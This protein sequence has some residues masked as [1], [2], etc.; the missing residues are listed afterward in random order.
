MKKAAIIHG[1]KGSPEGNWFR[2]LAS[3]LESIGYR[4]YIPQ[5]PTPEG[6]SLENWFEH[7]ETVVGELDQHSILIGHSVGAVFALRLLERLNSPIGAAILVS[8]FT[9]TLGLPEYDALNATF[10][11]GPFGWDRIRKNAAHIIC[12]SGSDDPYVPIE[13]GKDIADSLG[14]NHLVIKGGGHLNAES[15]F[16]KF[17]RLFEEIANVGAQNKLKAT[18]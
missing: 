1:T 16:T 12:L 4:T 8:G 13:Q 15:G 11:A 18:E 6:Q 2:W 5:F 10:I 14:V 7:F 17:P 9:G 3:E